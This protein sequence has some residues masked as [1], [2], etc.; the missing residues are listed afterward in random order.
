MDSIYLD[1]D[2]QHRDRIQHPNPYNFTINYSDNIITNSLTT[3]TNPI[4][5]AY[6]IKEWSWNSS[7]PIQI[8]TSGHQTLITDSG[9][10]ANIYS[11]GTIAQQYRVSNTSSGTGITFKMVNKPTVISNKLTAGELKICTYGSGYIPGETL[12][13]HRDDIVKSTG[14]TTNI[15]HALQPILMTKNFEITSGYEGGIAFPG[16]TEMAFKVSYLG[17]EDTWFIEGLHGLSNGD[18][19]YF[20]SAA[21]REFVGKAAGSPQKFLLYH[22]YY[23]INQAS[24][25]STSSF[26][27][28]LTSGGSVIEG[29]ADSTG[30]WIA[31]KT[32]F[33][34]DT[35]ATYATTGGSG[36]KR[37]I[38]LDITKYSN[39]EQIIPINSELGTGY[40]D[41]DILTLIKGNIDSDINTTGGS[42][43]AGH[44]T[45]INVDSDPQVK[46]PVGSNVYL[47]RTILV[48]V[49]TA[50]SSTTITIGGGTL[51]TVNN[52]SL[53][54]NQNPSGT[55][56][57]M[58]V[59]IRFRLGQSYALDASNIVK[60]NTIT[61]TSTVYHNANLQPLQTVNSSSGNGTG[62]IIATISEPVSQESVT[63]NVL[64]L[65]QIAYIFETGQNYEIGDTISI[66]DRSGLAHT[67]TLIEIGN[68]SSSKNNIKE[69]FDTELLDGSKYS[70]PN[71]LSRSIGVVGSGLNIYDSISDKT[72]SP[73][74]RYD[75]D[76]I[77]T[78]I[79]ERLS[80][81]RNITGNKIHLHNSRFF[82]LGLYDNFYKGLLFEDI[83]AGTSKTIT[84]FDSINNIL[85]LEND[86]VN[87]QTS[88]QNF[89]KITNPSTS[90]KI[91][92][93]DGSDNPK[94]YIDYIYEAVVYTGEINNIYDFIT[95]Q[96]VSVDGSSTKQY[97]IN[98]R[99][100]DKR[101]IHQYRTI[102]D[103]DVNSKMITLDRPLI[104]ITSHANQFGKIDNNN[105]S[106]VKYI[107]VA[108][109]NFQETL[110]NSAHYS[111]PVYPIELETYNTLDE[112]PT[113]TNASG[114]T[115]DISITNGTIANINDINIVQSGSGYESQNLSGTTYTD[116]SVSGYN[117]TV[118]E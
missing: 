29:S 27:L 16:S 86:I 15:S 113:N 66:T 45:S 114:L 103:Y 97:K 110:T 53:F 10:G 76:N 17:L 80:S 55:I 71:Y 75:M 116:T 70:E 72:T 56:K 74:Q 84:H 9:Y 37:T 89:W 61:S 67:L 58:L 100:Y 118:Y 59:D 57:V 3:S 1:I 35:V 2:S 107:H 73:I 34:T 104:G 12:K 39:D 105:I 54:Y 5:D 77:T 51:V 111:L 48:G 102:T 26:Q 32:W 46:F 78:R 22:T 50:N 30:D 96:T 115:V 36:S 18:Q 38:T 117:Y 93:P 31:K 11:S 62:M 23:I 49:I 87:D 43:A 95:E 60:N 91:F 47:S 69:I 65:N 83:T 7:P 64:L 19:I 13:I 109:N 28:S 94:D 90:S 68:E 6:P 98:N 20:T 24:G 14:A 52:S 79:F 106:S 40:K 99:S 41:G 81:V 21:G 85:T 42:I 101:I 63:G 44:T 8:I 92:V 112:S 25:V 82:N 33:D 4:S 88:I 108:S